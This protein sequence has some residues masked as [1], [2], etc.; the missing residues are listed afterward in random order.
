[1]GEGA[2]RKRNTKKHKKRQGMRK[3]RDET[4]DNVLNYVPNPLKGSIYRAEKYKKRIEV[5]CRS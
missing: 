2:K 4:E 5:E 1:M 3:N